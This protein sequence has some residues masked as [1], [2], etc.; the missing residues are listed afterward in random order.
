MKFRLEL[1]LLA[2]SLP[3]Q[4]S[5][6]ISLNVGPT[7]QY[8]RYTQGC[9][10][11]QSGLMMGPALDMQIK[12]AWKPMAYIGFRG[13]WDIPHICSDNGLIIDSNEYQLNAHLGFN[14]QR[15]CR[16]SLTPFTGIDFIHLSHQIKD[17]I[18]RHKYF[19]VNVPLGLEFNHYAS[20]CFT[21]GIKAYYDI[22]AWTRLKVSTPCLSDTEDCK[23]K[24]KRSH[25]F[26]IELPLE[27]HLRTDHRVGIDITWRP[28]F[29]WQKFGSEKNCCP[30]SCKTDNC[31]ITGTNDPDALNIPELKQWHFGSVVTVGITF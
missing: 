7:A 5:R 11:K 15:C 30:E 6:L 26:Q 10:P 4:A 22:D 13:L 12:K 31:C 17:D 2:L 1:C 20:E 14:F 27:Y 3:L 23:I 21:W 24:L 8:T 29:T 16:F 18:I 25:R 28:L 9:L 19:Q